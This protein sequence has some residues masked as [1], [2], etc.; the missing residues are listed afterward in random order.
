MLQ[1]PGLQALI[2]QLSIAISEVVPC[3]RHCTGYV[4][5]TVFIPSNCIETQELEFSLFS[6]IKQRLRNDVYQDAPVVQT[7]GRHSVCSY[8]FNFPLP[9]SFLPPPSLPLFCYIL[10]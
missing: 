8:S 1:F 10:R 5:D 3:V 9:P 2:H 7:H 6:E 4:M